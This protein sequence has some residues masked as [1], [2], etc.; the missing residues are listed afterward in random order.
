MENLHNKKAIITGGG[1]GLGKATALA[2]A[3][4]GVSVGITGRNEENLKQ[5][6]KELEA[7]G[8]QAV[9]AVFDVANA[10][11]VKSE[12]SRL[13]ERLGGVDILI[14]NAGIA[15]FGSF[16]DMDAHRWQEILMTNVMGIYHVTRE[17][18]P[19]LVAKNQGDIV[20][21]SSTAGLT[22]NANTSA[23][24]ASKFAVIGMSESLMKEVRKHNIRVCT[25][26]PSTIASDMSVDL[27]LTDGN[28]DSVLQPSDF[29]ELIIAN[30]KL[31]RRALLKSASLWSTNP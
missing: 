11:Q 31:P 15:E 18:L 30:L 28:P 19:H 9:Y 3:A 20:N 7:L 4:E 22:G 29:A 21:V 25:L 17:V 6:V 12:V 2:L 14:N 26:T 1:R 23:Y 13:I 8:V 24:S 27:G 16:L 5:T 10:D